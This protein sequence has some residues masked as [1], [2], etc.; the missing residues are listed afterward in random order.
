[1]RNTPSLNNQLLFFLDK[2]KS[3]RTINQ[4]H[5]AMENNETNIERSLID[6]LSKIGI[7]ASVKSDRYSLPYKYEVT[8]TGYGE[9]YLN[10]AYETPR[11]FNKI[12]KEL[13]HDDTYKI[14]FYVLLEVEDFFPMGKVNMKFR[15]YK[16]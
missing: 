13:L 8:H 12:I 11:F 10:A 6:L 1:M 15:Y 9:S 4:Y 14:R 3:K 5:T 7:Q 2:D 16:H